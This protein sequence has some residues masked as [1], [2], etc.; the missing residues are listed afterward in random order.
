MLEGWES[1]LLWVGTLTG[2]AEDE[3]ARKLPL[4]L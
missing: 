4:G 1:V 3:G 2:T